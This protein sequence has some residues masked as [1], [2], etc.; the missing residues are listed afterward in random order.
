MSHG[1]V[2]ARSLIHAHT[3]AADTQPSVGSGLFSQ[4]TRNCHR[5]LGSGVDSGARTS[6]VRRVCMNEGAGRDYVKAQGTKPAPDSVMAS[7]AGQ[8]SH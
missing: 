5:A 3:P 2:P 8:L 1:V 6:R 7:A 4:P